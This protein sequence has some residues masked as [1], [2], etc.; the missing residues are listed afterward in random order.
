MGSSKSFIASIAVHAGLAWAAFNMP[1]YF[2]FTKTDQDQIQPAYTMDLIE[3]KKTPTKKVKKKLKKRLA[4]PKPKKSFQQLP[5]KTLVTQK[6]KSP[7]QVEL[8]PK[9]VKT[10]TVDSGEPASKLAKNRLSE[11][12]QPSD[13]RFLR[14]R[15]GNRLPLYPVADR[16]RKR[17]GKV[18]VLGFV[19]NDGTVGKVQVEGSTGTPRMESSAIQAFSN[20]K[21]QKGQQ[22]WVKMPFEFTLDGEAR[23]I[24]V[25]NS[26]L[27]RS[28]Q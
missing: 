12:V 3:T 14:Q 27:L 22:G 4:R 11:P 28:I 18:I 24:S 1:Q 26:R 21:F 5:K 9:K 7:V 19:K 6:Q 10:A 25:R 13:G 20:Y 8:P 2:D 16:I 15:G 23:V 17:T